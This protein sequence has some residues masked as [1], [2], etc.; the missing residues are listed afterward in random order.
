MKTS[1]RVK[2]WTKFVLPGREMCNLSRARAGLRVSSNGHVG[3][4]FTPCGKVRITNRA[5]ESTAE[6]N[7]SVH[8][9]T[10][11]RRCSS[12]A[13]PSRV[14]D[15]HEAPPQRFLRQT[16]PH[17]LDPFATPYSL[18][19]H[20]QQERRRPGVC[21]NYDGQ[22]RIPHTGDVPRPTIR[23]STNSPLRDAAP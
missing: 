2:E 18:P 22:L 3:V 19:P 7:S 15:A 13:T 23:D 5:T 4:D 17:R 20:T 8:M 14:F 10:G 11:M 1:L 21:K 12:V 6:S 9:P 16:T